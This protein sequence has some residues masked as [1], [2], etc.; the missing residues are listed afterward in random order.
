VRALRRVFEAHLSRQN[1]R[2]L[3]SHFATLPGLAQQAEV[4]VL[5]LAETE[6]PSHI[7]SVSA[8]DIARRLSASRDGAGE[9]IR[10]L[11]G[12]HAASRADGWT[13]YFGAPVA[14]EDHARRACVAALRILAVERELNPGPRALQ[15]TGIGIDTGPC[16]VAVVPGR[17]EYTVIGTPTDVASRIRGLNRFFGTSVLVTERVRTA[18]GGGFLTRRLER[19]RLSGIDSALRVYELMAETGAAGAA[20]EAAEQFEE[21]VDLFEKGDLRGALAAFQNVLQIAPG[22]RPASVYA[23]RCR[24]PDTSRAG[25]P[26]SFPW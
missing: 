6:L 9:V 11:D 20:G 23:E 14:R 2:A 4:T 3:V 13:A 7:G 22:D 16:V 26:T 21:G 12:M 18:A 5:S 1:L 24:R 10:G 25:D 15:A 8:E 17:A 19:I